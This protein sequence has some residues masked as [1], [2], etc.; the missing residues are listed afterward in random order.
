VRRRGP[1]Q[2][3][4]A[5]WSIVTATVRPLR[6]APTHVAAPAIPAPATP[7]PPAPQGRKRPIPPP[8]DPAPAPTPRPAHRPGPRPPDPIEPGR[9]RRLDRA[10]DRPTATVDLHGL[11]QDRAREVLT[12]FILGAV[13]EHDRTVL[14]IT[15][16]G[17]LGDGVLRRRVPEW[18]ADPPLR[19]VVAGISLAHR[20]HGGEG[21]LY[22]A[23]KRP[24]A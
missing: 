3:D 2:V 24:T 20:R 7:P 12:R 6:P 10:R 9:R 16:K 14:V 22:V 11:N 19:S 13:A 17:A 8:A 1:D 21:A 5:L 4:L 15:G 18:L 23:L